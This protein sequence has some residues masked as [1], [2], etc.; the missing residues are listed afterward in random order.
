[1][2][3]DNGYKLWDMEK[4]KV[5]MSRNVK[6]DEDDK[7]DSNCE[8][9]H[10]CYIDFNECSS[11][12]IYK[13]PQKIAPLS[14]DLSLDVSNICTDTSNTSEVPTTEEMLNESEKSEMPEEPDKQDD[15]Q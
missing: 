1:M 5:V 2:D 11:S 7:R 6:F 3:G 13:S 10:D 14:D 4:K 15:I 9:S 8:I 12:Q